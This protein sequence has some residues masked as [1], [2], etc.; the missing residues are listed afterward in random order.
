MVISAV[1]LNLSHTVGYHM[2][3]PKFKLRNYRYLLSFYFHEV[4]Q[5][6]KTFITG[7]PVVGP[8]VISV[9]VVFVQKRTPGG[10]N[11]RGLG[12]RNGVLTSCFIRF[13]LAQIFLFLFRLFNSIFWDNFLYSFW[14]IQSS[15]C[16]QTEFNGIFFSSF[17]NWIQISL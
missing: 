6:L 8:V 2:T 10:G 9:L 7:L 3:S 17:H 15:N 11:T 1:T 16:W 12:P 13:S 5:P 4:L 14:S